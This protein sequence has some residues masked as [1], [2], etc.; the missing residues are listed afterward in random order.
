MEENPVQLPPIENVVG[1]RLMRNQMEEWMNDRYVSD[2]QTIPMRD[3][4]ENDIRIFKPE[5]VPSAGSPLVVLVHAGGFAMGTTRQ[6]SPF[7][8]GHSHLHGAT[9]VNV[10]HRL[11]PEHVFPTAPNDIW[12]AVKW[13]SVN[14]ASLRADIQAGFVLGGVSSGANLAAV[15]AQRAVQEGLSPALTGVWMCMPCILDKEIIPPEYADV[16]I[17]REQAANATLVDTQN[18]YS[19]IETSKPDVRSPDWSPFNFPEPHKGMP[20]C[21]IQVSGAD[22]MRDDGLIYERALR[23]AGVKTKLDVY[24]GVP[25]WHFGFFPSLQASKRAQCDAVQG[26]GWLLGKSTDPED[27]LGA[28][29]PPV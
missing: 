6:L 2:I 29:G 17:S 24:P 15:T 25:H 7:A 22:P 1:M 23:K 28:M 19:V 21:Y 13:L 11:A 27:I 20:P 10:T 26:V 8:Q 14:A 9:V 16:F 3:G 18:L 12:D 4:H 5:K